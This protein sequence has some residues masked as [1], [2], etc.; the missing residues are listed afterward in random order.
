MGDARAR[1]PPT[2]P[3]GGGRGVAL[4]TNRSPAA[5]EAGAPRA[6]GSANSAGA[7]SASGHRRPG[8]A[9]PRP[10]SATLSVPSLSPPV[11]APHG[12]ARFQTPHFVSRGRGRGDW[13]EGAGRA[14]RLR[15][16]RRPETNAWRGHGG[17]RGGRAA[18]GDRRVI[19]R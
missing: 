9:A 18:P 17:Q 10:P 5:P 15:V 1:A 14:V 7:A 19:A 16:S 2:A 12:P 8:E 3:A 13:Q 6:E 11:C 4:R